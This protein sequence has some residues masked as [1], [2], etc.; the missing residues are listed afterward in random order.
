MS[1]SI[2]LGLFDDAPPFVTPPAPPSVKV[3]PITLGAQPVVRLSL[4]PKLAVRPRRRAPP[5]R[6]LT[7]RD[8]PAYSQEQI[9]EV[10]RIIAEIKSDRVLLGYRDIQD[11]FGVSKATANRRMKDGLVPGVRI[12]DGVVSRDGGVRRF[13]H[14]QVKWL[15]LAVRST[16]H[17]GAANDAQL[18]SG[19][20]ALR[21][22]A[23]K[24]MKDIETVAPNGDDAIAA[25]EAILPLVRLLARQAARED[26]ARALEAERANPSDG[27]RG[28]RKSSEET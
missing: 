5:S 3:S 12:Q 17:P 6:L 23:E 15:L 19:T 25:A 16:R 10:D 26:Y 27:A 1:S 22:L 13:S 4:G 28:A 18:S 14:E 11:M 20:D 8:M 9:A 24:S 7:D 21:P 2:Q